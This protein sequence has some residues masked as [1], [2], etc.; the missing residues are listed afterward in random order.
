MNGL[1]KGALL[2]LVVL[3]LYL[4]LLMGYDKKK[5]RTHQWRIPEKR[6]L[7]LGVIGGGLGGLVGQQVFRHK[8]REPKFT[9]CFILG[10]LVA[11]FLM[12]LVR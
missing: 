3:N 4:F 11:G 2:Y 1:E 6:L 12:W 5:A 7:I 9:M 10:L 8:T